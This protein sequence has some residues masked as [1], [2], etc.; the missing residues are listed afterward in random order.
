[1]YVLELD[2][3]VFRDRLATGQDGDVLEHGLAAIAEARRPDGGNLETAA[4]LVDDE[5]SERLALDVLSDDQKRLA[6][7]HDS[8]EH[9]KHRLQAGDIL[10]VDEDVGVLALGDHLLGVGDEVRREVAAVEL[11]ALDDVELGVEALG[12][13]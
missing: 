2:A 8:L 12:L 1:G 10:L 6:R 11:H 13:L 4:Q 5:R 9:G 3:E 7:L